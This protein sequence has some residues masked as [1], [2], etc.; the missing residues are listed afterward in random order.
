[1]QAAELNPSAT[2]P[3]EQAILD[4]AEHL[5]S[6]KGFAAAAI[7]EIARQAGVSKAN[8]FHHFSSKK[9]LYLAV[10]RRVCERTTA[11]LFLDAQATGQTACRQLEHFVASHLQ[12]LLQNRRATRLILREVTYADFREGREL[13]EQVLAGYFDRLVSLVSAGQR[14]GM[15]RADFEPALLAHLL[16]GANNFY[17]QT[18]SVLPHL[19]DAP[20]AQDPDQFVTELFR[21]ILTG[22]AGDRDA[23]SG[24]AQR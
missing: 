9:A 6:E 12:G 20:F 5:F 13:A 8:V 2:P 11:S 21:L 18:R 4:A 17:F 24:G 19:T 23:S 22:V 7:N 3:G 16:V 14:E 10:L 1:M 15:L